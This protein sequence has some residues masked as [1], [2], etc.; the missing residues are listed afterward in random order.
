[1]GDNYPKV[2]VA[3]VQAASVLLDRE[4]TVQKA[5]KLIKEAGNSKANLVVFPEGFIPAH[6]IWYHFYPATSQTAI[7]FSVELFKNSVEVPGREIEELCKSARE[8]HIYTIIGF[9]EKLP[10]TTGTRYNSQVIITSEGVIIG[11]RR[12]IMPTVGERLVHFF[13]YIS[14]VSS[15]DYSRKENAYQNN[16]IIF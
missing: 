1:M 8:S 10:N 14:I 4:T 5:C 7:E 13:S 3:A 15:P 9:C 6:P 11:T 2:R 12:K 16:E